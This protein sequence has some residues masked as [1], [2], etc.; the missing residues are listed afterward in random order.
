MGI[1]FLSGKAAIQ[2]LL[3]I[4]RNLRYNGSRVHLN[5]GFGRCPPEIGLPRAPL[6]NQV[7]LT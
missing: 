1:T 2:L 4:A 5:I 7:L 6:E 3:V